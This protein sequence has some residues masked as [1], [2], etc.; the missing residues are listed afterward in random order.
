MRVFHYFE[1]TWKLLLAIS[2]FGYVL[3][4]EVTPAFVSYLE[5]EFYLQEFPILLH[6]SAVIPAISLQQ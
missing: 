1:F 4:K 6:S 2:S 5:L 3:L